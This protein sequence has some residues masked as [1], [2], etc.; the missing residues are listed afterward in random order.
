MVEDAAV[1]V[2]RVVSA[3][4]AE[5]YRAWTDPERLAEWFGPGA[6][7]VASAEVDLRPGGAYRIVFL[8]H[9]SGPVTLVG[10]Y[11]EIEPPSRLVFT[12]S[13]RHSW[14]DQ[15]ESLVTVELADLGER[16]LVAVTHAR[17]G[18]DE[19]AYRGGWE[20]GL[21]KLVRRFAGASVPSEEEETC[22]WPSTR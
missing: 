11:R 4:R 16:T 13:W 15:P 1:R 17:F 8:G 2:S 6:F 12:W 3:P 7:T 21:D 5:V 19:A 9:P 14:P 18:A 22:P 10:A 20:S